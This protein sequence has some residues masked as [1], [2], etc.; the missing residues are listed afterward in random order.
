MLN[1]KDIIS[2][3][4]SNMYD[5]I[6]GMDS[7][8][9]DSIKIMEN[10]KSISINCNN[11]IICG[12][13]GSAIGADFVKNIVSQSI[14]IPIYVNRT[15]VLP[16]WVNSKSLVILC[17]YSG[18]TEETIS[19]Y[20][21]TLSRKID[22]IIITSNGFLLRESNKHNFQKIKLPIGMQ[23]RVAFGYSSSVLLI[24]LQK[25]N[26]IDNKLIDDLT[27]IIENIKQTSEMFSDFTSN[28]N[29]ALNLASNIYDKYPIIYSTPLTE[30]LAV[31]FRGQL[32]ENGK[33][34]SSHNILPE[35]N[36]NEI[37][38]FSKSNNNFF[39]V[40]IDDIDDHSQISKRIKI[41]SSILS[42]K[43][44]NYFYKTSG[45]N[46]IERMYNG[47]LFFDWVSFYVSIFRK[48][49][50]TPVNKIKTLKKLLS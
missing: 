37:E 14:N 43:C 41:T 35:Q 28:N 8:I 23:P 29:K 27:K 6:K 42:E 40:W 48:I 13:G 10:F 3:D 47:I 20:E 24:L 32:A 15:Y 12:M 36:H 38:G 33:I 18:D 16:K 46:L 11:V 4:L 34:L 22:P 45:N 49:D 30:T 9:I 7:Q 31:R 17:S 26:L 2:Y 25:L 21:E 1:K 19:C 50:P 5:S 39:V 44:E